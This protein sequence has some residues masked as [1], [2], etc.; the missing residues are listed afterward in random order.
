MEA[1]PLTIFKT[2]MDNGYNNTG[3]KRELIVIFAHY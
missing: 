3:F 2:K 1:A